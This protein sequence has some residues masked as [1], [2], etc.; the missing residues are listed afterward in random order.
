MPPLGR[1]LLE[2]R[3]RPGRPTR[4]P[5]PSSPTPMWETDAELDIGILPSRGVVRLLVCLRR[6][7]GRGSNHGSINGIDKPKFFFCL[8]IEKSFSLAGPSYP[9]YSAHRGSGVI[10]YFARLR[11]SCRIRIAQFEYEG[12]GPGYALSFGVFWDFW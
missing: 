11:G 8:L 1:D 4:S 12:L 10:F 7:R 6:P 9:T 2:R 3:R 5:S